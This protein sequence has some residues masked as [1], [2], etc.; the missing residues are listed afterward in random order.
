[1]SA[2]SRAVIRPGIKGIHA[3]GDLDAGTA[4]IVHKRALDDILR[5]RNCARAPNFQFT[6]TDGGCEGCSK[7]YYFCCIAGWNISCSGLIIV[8]M[9]SCPK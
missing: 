8:P 6:A 5:K 9:Q 4:E 2:R 1:M 7:A 3:R